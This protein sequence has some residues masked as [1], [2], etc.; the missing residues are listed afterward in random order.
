MENSP[1]L[2]Q[3]A[4]S[5]DSLSFG[6][7]MVR[8]LSHREYE[9]SIRDLFGYEFDAEASFVADNIEEGFDNHPEA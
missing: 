4:E 8:R 1:F 9:N 7:R 5:C 6:R 3:Q 2:Y